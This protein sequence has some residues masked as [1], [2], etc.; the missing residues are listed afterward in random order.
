MALCASLSIF[1]FRLTALWVV[2]LTRYALAARRGHRSEAPLQG[3]CRGGNRA[4]QADEV[5]VSQEVAQRDLDKTRPALGKSLQALDALDKEIKSFPKSPLLV[6]ANS[7]F[8][9]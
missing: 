1:F 8:G 4:Y 7:P 3:V 2:S 5:K 9:A 6:N